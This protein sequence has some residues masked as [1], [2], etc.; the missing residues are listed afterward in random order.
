MRRGV[1]NYS[2]SDLGRNV[3]F[4]GCDL[5]DDIVIDGSGLLEWTAPGEVRSNFCVF[6]VPSNCNTGFWWNG[7]LTVSTANKSLIVEEFAVSELVMVSSGVLF[8]EFTRIETGELGFASAT[9]TLNGT[10]V[11]VADP[12]LL[13]SVF[14]VSSVRDAPIQNPTASLASLTEADVKRVAFHAAIELVRFLFNETLETQRGD[15]SHT[16]PCGTSDVTVDT[17][18]NLPTIDA[19]WSLCEAGG[20]FL[21]G[22]FSMSRQTFSEDRIEMRV[23]GNLGLTGGVPEINLDELAWL[24]TF[25]DG[26]TSRISGHIKAGGDRREF[27]FDLILDD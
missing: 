18:A 14:D 8:P 2:N 24:L 19:R 16:Q 13:E 1:I 7:D 10:E 5:G 20:V 6:G 17:V 25:R 22:D 21:S 23:T 12:N 11:E 9:A 4:S 15:H 27:A 26:S 3:T